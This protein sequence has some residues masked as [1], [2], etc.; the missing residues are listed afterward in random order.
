MPAK[1][2]SYSASMPTQRS[3]V[4]S[5]GAVGGVLE[6]RGLADPRLAAQHERD[7]ALAACAL[8]ERIEGGPLGLTPDEHLVAILIPT[9]V[10]GDWEGD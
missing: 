5:R 8:Q 2:S 6:Q 1:G 4:M 9:D 3:T 7:A 10:G